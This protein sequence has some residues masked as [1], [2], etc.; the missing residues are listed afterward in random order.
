MGFLDDPPITC[1]LD[2]EGKLVHV[3]E[4]PNGNACRCTCPACGEPLCAVQ[5][6]SRMHFFRH[7]AHRSCKWAL[8]AVLQSRAEAVLAERG[9]MIFPALSYYD[10]A[11]R[12]HLSLSQ[13]VEM[14]LGDVREQEMGGWGVPATA[15]AVDCGEKGVRQVALVAWAAFEPG[16]EQYD[17]LAAAGYDV[18]SANIQQLHER[19]KAAEGRHADKKGILDY[20][21]SAELMARVLC[22][23]LAGNLRWERN[24][25][26]RAKK[27]ESLEVAG[28]LEAERAERD[29]L[30]RE[31]QAREAEK[32]R[33]EARRLEALRKEEAAA[34]AARRAAERE[35]AEAARREQEAAEDAERRERRDRAAAKEAEMIRGKGLVPVLITRTAVAAFAEPCPM[36]GGRADAVA[37]CGV[38]RLS[39]RR[40]PFAVGKGTFYVL[41]A[42]GV[43]KRSKAAGPGE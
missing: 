3:D 4:V 5:G 24:A 27:S 22:G 38:F 7:L 19:I 10:H 17:S 34:E 23:D 29:R 16:A 31:E 32:R 28:R 9:R 40:C 18:V 43:D 8:D 42:H 12:K 33:E 20:I 21:Q 13:A 2:R 11:E 35:R 25:K 15:F 37:D 1:A 36:T 39:T 30:R 14:S 26:A 6:S 41:C